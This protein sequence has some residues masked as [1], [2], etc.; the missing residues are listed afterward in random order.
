MILLG[1]QNLSSRLTEVGEKS[2]LKAETFDTEDEVE[3]GLRKIGLEVNQTG[4]NR[5]PISGFVI[6]TACKTSGSTVM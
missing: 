4:Q 6:S 5:I 3:T 2:P 1:Q